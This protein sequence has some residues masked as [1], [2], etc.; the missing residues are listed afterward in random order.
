MRVYSNH[1]LKISICI[2]RVQKSEHGIIQSLIILLWK[3][4]ISQHTFTFN[5]SLLTTVGTALGLEVRSAL[6]TWNTS[7]VPSVL[8]RSITV[9]RAQN[10]PLRVTESLKM[11]FI[12]LVHYM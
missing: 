5:T 6:T 3:C 9:A 4:G 11:Q 7:T 12:L 1:T 2:K 10:I 8:Q